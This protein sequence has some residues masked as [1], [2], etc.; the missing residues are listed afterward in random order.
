MNVTLS[1]RE[2]ISDLW[3]FKPSKEGKYTE[4]HVIDAYL[5]GKKTGLESH[6]KA[7]VKALEQN[8][9]LCGNYTEQV[10]NFLKE[11]SI[12]PQDAF[13]K[14]SKFDLF[15]VIICVPEKD[16]LNEKF[17][18]VYD[19]ISEFEVKNNSSKDSTFQVEFSFLDF[20]DQYCVNTLNSDGYILRFKK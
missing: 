6:H 20:Q 9:D 19:Y 16:F 17:F 13:L 8:V 10:F 15:N 1:K 7:L 5:Q 2:S 4:D 12:E 3:E 11:Q 14:I 18:G